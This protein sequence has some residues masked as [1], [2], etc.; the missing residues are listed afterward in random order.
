MDEAF[1]YIPDGFVL[2][3]GKA[4]VD[5]GERAGAPPDDSV[6]HVIDT[7]GCLVTPGLINMHQ[8]HW[9]N[10][11]KGLSQGLYLEDWVKQL[12][13]PATKA[14]R[15]EDYLV[16]MRLA[17][18]EM[19]LSGTSTFFN[20]SVTGMDY[21]SVSALAEVSESTGIRQYFGK[22]LRAKPHDGVAKHRADVE[23]LLQEYPHGL[24]RRFCVN[25][26]FESG[27]HWLESGATDV[28]LANYAARLVRE[29][30]VPLSDHITGGTGFRSVKD[31]RLREGSGEVTWLLRHG[32]LTPRTLLVHAPWIDE[33]EVL[34]A[35]ECGASI[36]TCPPSSAFT[37]GG[38]APLGA[39]IEGGINL[40]LGSD[41][42]MVN[43]S[44]D[45]LDQMRECFLLT[46]A[47]Y[48]TPA[49]IQIPQ[50]W[51][52]S[53]R[54]GARALGFAGRL[55]ELSPGAVADVSVFDLSAPHYGGAL[56]PPANLILSG[57]TR[58]VK[59][60]IVNGDIVVDPS[61]I[62]TFDVSDTVREAR[63]LAHDLAHRARLLH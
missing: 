61:G 36:V 62:T 5:V 55:G 13:F 50:L 35:A 54:N 26:V 19:L 33:G 32:L 15:R 29:F 42:P 27:Q 6:G 1:T 41:G 25:L 23:R 8:H 59:W 9:Y 49:K 45:M 12:L 16:S 60:V 4:I 7:E 3:E 18:A 47:K 53:T 31:F 2:L 51:S 38:I 56:N 63:G 11:L 58:R 30:Q 17:A 28:D 10:L 14:L 37:A 46:N 20:H 43:D 40:A 39:F 52:M 57:S 34:A 21:D 24:D 44:V 22:E 48:L